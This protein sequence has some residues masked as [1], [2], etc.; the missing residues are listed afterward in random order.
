MPSY[1]DD[2]TLSVG[3]DPQDALNTADKLS[4]NLEKIFNKASGKKLSAS[5]KSTL[6]QMDA[7]GQK[8]RIVS[9]DMR[10][11]EHVNLPTERFRELEKQLEQARNEQTKLTDRMTKFQALGGKTTS[12]AFKSMA[13]D[14][15]QLQTRITDI[16]S[17]MQ[18]LR[19]TGNAFVPGVETEEYQQLAE[20]LNTINNRMVILQTRVGEMGGLHPVVDRLRSVFEKLRD[21]IHNTATHLKQMIG[22]AIH[23][24]ISKLS[25]AISSLGKNT[26]SSNMNFKKGLRLLLQYG[27]GVRSLFFLVRRIRKFIGEGIN[28]MAESYAPFADVMNRFKTSLEGLKNSIGAA[29]MPILSVVLP[30]LTRLIDAISA[31]IGKVSMLF[32][33]LRGQT[34]YL[35]GSATKAQK[36]Y[37]SAMGGTAKKADE[38][39]RQL[40]G[41]DDVEILK[42]PNDSSGGGGGGGG[43]GD[44]GFGNIFETVPID[45]EMVEFMERIKKVFEL[46]DWEWLGKI[47][48]GGINKAFAKAKELIDSTAL[49]DKIA[50]VLTA[51]TET[52]NSLISGIDWEL[53]GSTFASGVNLVVDTLNRFL[54]GINW[55]N[56]AF[57]LAQGL[58]NLI[59]NVDWK[60]L[61]SLFA[62][63][64]NVIIESLYGFVTGFDFKTSA[65]KLAE[66]LNQFISDINWAD[67]GKAISD[68]IK[69]ALTFLSTTIQEFDWYALGQDVKE[70]LANVDWSG[71]VQSAFE[72]FG[73][74]MGGL[75]EF[76]WGLIEDAL[77]SVKEYF[78]GKIQE[79]V[80]MGGDIGDGLLYGIGQAFLDIGTWIY[81]N[82]F[83][84]IYDGIKKAFG[85]SS[86]A[87]EMKP[88]GKNITA[89]LKDGMLEGF[90]NAK[91]WIQEHIFDPIKDVLGDASVTI[92]VGLEKAKQWAKDAWAVLQDAGK[93][94]ITTVQAAV[95]RAGTWVAEA[96]SAAT[97]KAETVVRTVQSAVQKA[98]TWI[99]DA[100]SAANLSSSTV[101]KTVQSVVQKAS[102]WIADAWSAANMIKGTVVKT[103]QSAVQKASTWI[104]DAWSAANMARATI[105]KT[106]EA[107]VKKA[108][109]WIADAWTA[110][111]MAKGTVIKTVES[112]VK[113][114]STWVADA[115]AAAKTT[116]GT[117]K[118]TLQISVT[119]IGNKLAEAWKVITGKASGGVYSVGAGWSKLPQFASGGRIGSMSMRYWN[120]LPKYAAGTSSAHGTVF[121]AGENGAE[122]VGNVNGK[123]E[124]LN[125]SQIASA[126]YSAVRSALGE[127]VNGIASF[128][129]HKLSECANAVITSVMMMETSFNRLVTGSEI[130]HGIATISDILTQINTLSTQTLVPAIVNGNVIPSAINVSLDSDTT[131]LLHTMAD[132]LRDRPVFTQDELRSI[133]EDVIR[134]YLNI[135]FYI[136]N[137]QIAR[138]AN[139]GNI[140]LDRRYKR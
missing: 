29:F 82:V 55:F 92:E 83:K 114:G 47:I 132:T 134:R 34:T 95:K 68:G 58:N 50:F 5:F 110:A 96:W 94:V 81:D 93:T 20:E 19:N 18:N 111:K 17:Q 135:E 39:Q 74:A 124:I 90:R 40:A 108:S 106:V 91:K 125:K 43:A 102:T 62:N 86:P 45:Q 138:A 103:V 80:D 112:I 33:L 48:A 35:K 72:L 140:S 122:I 12:S 109:T 27:I 56:L 137:E 24:G 77:N 85:I 139:A 88:L 46:Q 10:N 70:F 126:I 69:G 52:F 60:A 117:V 8:M 6:N 66:G 100:W 59:L 73:S 7:L 14:A 32:A 11:L 127:T 130:T 97:M 64:L 49:H 61:G 99:A 9:E 30:I 115:W 25:S 129:S 107:V 37:G 67:A 16:R 89:G 3:L 15:Q 4:A 41:F 21:I 76:I 71:I 36:G 113:K 128:I 105:T 23:R 1:N 44:S 101:T 42:S 38:L 87:K 31:V 53:I 136:G 51:I 79:Y 120:S 75:A 118:K 22:T 119:W 98:S 116:A 78:N 2:V 28:N 54:T 121:V 131:S 26:H 65:L 13:Y 63:R 133:I 123:T 104:A 57:S 84:P